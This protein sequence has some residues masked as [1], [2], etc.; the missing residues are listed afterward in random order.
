MITK[1]NAPKVVRPPMT[2]I[3]H[4]GHPDIICRMSISLDEVKHTAQLARL[5]LDEAELKAFQ[6]EL[7]A[8]L[9]HFEDIQAIDTTGLVP[10]P[11]AVELTNVWSEDQVEQGLSREEALEGAFKTR[12]GLFIV[13][14]VIEESH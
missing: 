13:P 4:Y 1:V 5:E 9:G 3:S 12:A 2:G 7:N 11:H 6:L 14:T 10:K 8:L